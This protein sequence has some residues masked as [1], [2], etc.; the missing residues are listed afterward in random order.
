MKVSG[1]YFGGDNK[2]CALGVLLK[3][4]W[5]MDISMVASWKSEMKKHT[6][7]SQEQLDEIQDM[8]DSSSLTFPEIADQI[9]N[10][11]K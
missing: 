10:M 3:K 5:E 4:M 1:R 8:N 7:L 6:G 2:A 11:V 9:E